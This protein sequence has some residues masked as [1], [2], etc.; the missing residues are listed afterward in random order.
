MNRLSIYEPLA[1]MEKI[2]SNTSPVIQSKKYF[3]DEKE[4]L[5]TLEI[6]VPGFTKD[7]INVEI[8]GDYLLIKGND[9]ESYWTGD[10]NQKFKLPGSVEKSSVKANV[11]NGILKLN[12][13]KKKE[14]LSRKVIV[15]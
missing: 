6:P 13:G 8:D 14:S 4:D 3:V 11:I 2:L 15:E 9:N 12:I 1:M 5:F 10:F 7:D